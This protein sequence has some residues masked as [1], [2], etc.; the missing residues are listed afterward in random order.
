MKTVRLTS[1]T[2]SQTNLRH[3]NLHIHSHLHKHSGTVTRAVLVNALMPTT[4]PSNPHPKQP[5]SSD[6]RPAAHMTGRCTQHWTTLHK[7]RCAKAN[8][9][10]AR[11]P[12][13]A[14]KHCSRGAA[15]FI[16]VTQLLIKPTTVPEVHAVHHFT[17]AQAMT[18]CP[19]AHQKQ[20]Q[21]YSCHWPHLLLHCPQQHC[22]CKCCR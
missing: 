8:K 1:A 5:L 12:S 22:C 7:P 13:S 15:C 18:C 9:V 21:P 10:T 16:R 3:N 6:G 11:A 20:R 2:P 19:T 14:R 4:Y 17:A